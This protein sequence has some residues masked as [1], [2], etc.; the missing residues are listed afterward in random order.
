MFQQFVRL[1]LGRIAIIA[2]G[3]DRYIRWDGYSLHLVNTLEHGIGNICGIG[4][5]ALRHGNGHGRILAGCLMRCRAGVG[6]SKEHIVGR[7]GG[8]IHNAVRHI[9]QIDGATMVNRDHNRLKVFAAGKQIARIDADLAVVLSKAPGLYACIGSLQM[10]N[11]S[12]GRQTISVQLGCTE[13]NAHGARKSANDRRLRDIV[14][15]LNTMLYLV[16]N[17]AKLIAVVVFPPQSE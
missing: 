7:V 14:N 10:P 11:D 1:G 4:S 16:R 5:L 2:R 13:H 3:R 17:G 6:C 9:A 15:L 8:A 12:H